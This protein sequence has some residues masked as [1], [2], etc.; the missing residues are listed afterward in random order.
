MYY[1]VVSNQSIG[2][3]TNKQMNIAFIIF[4][5]HILQSVDLLR[6]SIAPIKITTSYQKFITA[7]ALLQ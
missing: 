7:Y 1:S 5:V 6:N 4:H 2:A 3:N